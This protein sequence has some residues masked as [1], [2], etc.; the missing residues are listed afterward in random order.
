MRVLTRHTGRVIIRRK[1]VITP[2]RT[3]LL[4][5]VGAAIMVSLAIVL[6]AVTPASAAGT[7]S[8]SGQVFA[9]HQ[10]G[11]V[12]VPDGAVRLT[13]ERWD[14]SAWIPTSATTINGAL[15]LYTL[16]GLEVGLYQLHMVGTV[17]DTY[18]EAIDGFHGSFTISD[19]GQVITDHRVNLQIYRAV[20][21]ALLLPNGTAVSPG[22]ASV[23][24]YSS[25]T[26]IAGPQAVGTGGTFTFR[27]APTS[28]EIKVTYLGSEKAVGRAFAYTIAFNA[29]DAVTASF[30]LDYAYTYSGHVDIGALGNPAA[31]GDVTISWMILG[32]QYTSTTDSAGDFKITGLLGYSTNFVFASADPWLRTVT[33][34]V[35]LV[36]NTDVTGA[37]IILPRISGASGRVQNSSGEPLAGISVALVNSDGGQGGVYADFTRATTDATGYYELRPIN[38]YVA[39]DLVFTDP[40]GIYSTTQWDGSG[41]YYY[42]D[43]FHIQPGEHVADVDVVMP[44]RNSISGRVDGAN[45]TSAE[46]DQTHVI[47]DLQLYD[48]STDE[49]VVVDEFGVAHDG[50]YS[51]PGLFPDDYRLAI[52]YL[53]SQGFKPVT[54]DVISLDEAQDYVQNFYLTTSTSVA[55]PFADVSHAHAFYPDIEWMYERGLTNGY[56]EGTGARDFRPAESVS[57][58]AM[59]AFLYR[60]RNPVGFVAPSTPSFADVPATHPFYREIEWLKAQGITTGTPGPGG[61][62]LFEPDAD[63]TR[64]AMAAFLYRMAGSPAF[65]SPS[66]ATFADVPTGSTFAKQIEWMKAKGLTNGYVDGFHPT[67]AV[68]R[69]AMAAFLHRF[70]VSVAG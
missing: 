28:Y 21:G 26:L 32:T 23:S 53:G 33:K 11:W 2:H 4:R 69:Q 36:G 31:A 66:H 16:T 65:T 3:G 27:L 9:A 63:V 13:A 39:Y 68:S 35:N 7:A 52:V 17:P 19:E 48:Y 51:I 58:Q 43:L 24:V 25:G 56:L 6:G 38:N 62:L 18:V 59:A 46:F 42:A 8:L 22:D 15:G 70:S 14:G 57:R 55:L 45:L 29:P 50:T 40:A 41:T 61:T 44:H 67:E 5:A 12:S 49:W 30:Q 37:S 20:Q 64:Q 60:Y 54:S 47:L 1:L 10:S 34:F